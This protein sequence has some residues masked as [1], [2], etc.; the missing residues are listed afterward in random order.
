MPV[1]PPAPNPVPPIAE[2]PDRIKGVPR[3]DQHTIATVKIPLSYLFK[4]S[5]LLDY[6][7]KGV[8][9]ESQFVA[10]CGLSETCHDEGSG[11]LMRT[12]ENQEKQP[13]KNCKSQ[14]G[15]DLR[16]NLAPNAPRKFFW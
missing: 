7:F 16:G 14:S 13:G 4:R 5:R 1:K 9:D 11:R 3:S 2:H 10:P 12:S 8:R 6:A 15:K